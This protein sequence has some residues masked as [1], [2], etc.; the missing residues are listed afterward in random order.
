MRGAGV[1]LRHIRFQAFRY[2][3]PAFSSDP[4]HVAYYS[5]TFAPQEEVELSY[6]TF[7]YGQKDGGPFL[8]C[9]AL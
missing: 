8:H 9:H 3:I 1:A 6:A 5:A 7:T 4:N 2:V